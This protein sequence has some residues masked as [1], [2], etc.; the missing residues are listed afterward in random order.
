MADP[1]IPLVALIRGV[2]VG[3][4]HKLSMA[5]LRS[6]LFD[7]GFPDVRTHI[8][9]G[10]LLITPSS[11]PRRLAKTLEHT[12]EDGFGL[13]VRV[14]TRTR[15]E[16]ED[17]IARNPF[18]KPGMKPSSLHAVFL[19]SAPAAK[20]VADLDPDRSPPDRFVVSSKEIYLHYPNGSGR[21]KLNL[22]YFERKL[23]VAGTARN[24]NTVTK[25]LELLDG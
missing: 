21:S 3:G 8:Q 13:E 20:R 7:A 22:D 1:A 19:E 15:R 9:S 23:G 18:L 5:D 17:I 14:I 24:W 4:R 2:N 11:D 10:N 25:L 6:T 16:L 12:I